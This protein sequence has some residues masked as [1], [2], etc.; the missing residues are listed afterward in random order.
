MQGPGPRQE[1]HVALR[2]A[3]IQS[4]RRFIR[5]SRNS[6]SSSSSWWGHV[7]GRREESE[8]RDEIYCMYMCVY[9]HTDFSIYLSSHL[10]I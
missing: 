9:T 3:R 2:R 5:S 8:E 10:T 7:E 6:R 1:V 4:S